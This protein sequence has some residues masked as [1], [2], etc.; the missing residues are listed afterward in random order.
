[1]SPEG[2]E[3]LV[4][5]FRRELAAHCY[6]MLGSLADAE[7]QVQ[8]TLLRAWRGIDGFEG[9]SSVRSWLYRI[10]TNA[11][12]DVLRLRPRRA[13]PYFDLGSSQDPRL[14]PPVDEEVLW[15]EPAPASLIGDAT[16]IGP[17]AR[18]AARESVQLAFVVALQHLPA[19]QRAAVILR[20]VLGW[21]AAE[22]AELLDT[23]VA[24]VNSALQRA[25]ETLDARR[26]RP[27]ARLDDAARE[28]VL[29]RYIAAWEQGDVDALAALLHHDVITSMPPQPGWFRG[30]DPLI[31]LIRRKIGVAGAQ[32]LLV[33]EGADEMAIGF[34]RNDLGPPEHVAHGI[35]IIVLDGDAVREI[36]AF[37]DVALFARFGLP[38][39]LR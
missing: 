16:E 19:Q 13:L 29:G 35:Q 31:A 1:M 17:E 28:A 6:R 36:H 25:R 9:R 7:D 10:A 20:D 21:S 8:E 33:A 37:T 4:R 2:F 18:Y 39:V 23:T 15:V 11:C 30:R 24:A 5:P 26:A 12:L 32:R 27:P 22:V 38:P 3:E 34:Y 14:P